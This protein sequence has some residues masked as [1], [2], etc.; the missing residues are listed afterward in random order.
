MWLPVLRHERSLVWIFVFI[1]FGST[2]ANFLD[3]GSWSFYFDCMA[4]RLFRIYNVF[5]N[6][7]FASID[8]WSNSFPQHHCP[9]NVY[10]EESSIIRLSKKWAHE[11]IQNRWP[12]KTAPINSKRVDSQRVQCHLRIETTLVLL[13]IKVL[14]DVQQCVV[15]SLVSSIDP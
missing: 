10:V 15:I 8:I 6:L 14:G 1:F 3:W 2:C 9:N 5:F 12:E 13:P 11:Q 7:C 4:E